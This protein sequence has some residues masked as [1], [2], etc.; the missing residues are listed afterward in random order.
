MTVGQS[1]EIRGV[2][3][4]GFTGTLART[5][6]GRTGV[7]SRVKVGGTAFYTGRNEFI[8]E[9]GDPFAFGF[10]LPYRFADLKYR[11]PWEREK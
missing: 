9:P 4:Q 10:E 6:A 5:Y 11:S 1:C 7:A 8:C 3:G 2:S